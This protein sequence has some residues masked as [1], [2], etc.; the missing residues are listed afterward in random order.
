MLRGTLSRCVL[1]YDENTSTLDQA[2]VSG[3][4]NPEDEAKVVGIGEETLQRMR[5]GAM[6]LRG[7][8][9]VKIADDGDL[10]LANTAVEDVAKFFDLLEEEGRRTDIEPFALLRKL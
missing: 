2:N 3:V 4:N 8:V 1:P 9:R 6:A 10:D 7:L 5:E